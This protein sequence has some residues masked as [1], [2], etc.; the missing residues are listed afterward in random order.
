VRVARPAAASDW[1]HVGIGLDGK[2]GTAARAHVDAANVWRKRHR[3][4]HGKARGTKCQVVAAMRA[5]FLRYGI[6]PEPPVSREF[7]DYLGDVVEQEPQGCV[8]VFARHPVLFISACV[9]TYVYSNTYMHV[10]ARIHTHTPPRTRKH[11]HTH[12]YT[13]TYQPVFMHWS[14]T[15]IHTHTYIHTCLLACILTF[16]ERER[17]SERERAKEREREKRECV[18]EGGRERVSEREGGR[19]RDVHYQRVEVRAGLHTLVAAARAR[20]RQG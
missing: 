16:R 18:C 17:E 13:H 6:D 2:P 12:T 5:Q 14:H 15:Q 19:E 8:I 7:L 4:G 11:A 20:E 1:A 9:Y 3:G 10:R